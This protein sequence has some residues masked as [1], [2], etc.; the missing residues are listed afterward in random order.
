MMT[1]RSEDAKTTPR[2]AS[3]QPYELSYFARKH[4]IARAQA[5]Q[6]LDRSKSRDA[7][8]QPWRLRSPIVTAR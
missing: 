4:G 5:R 3:G 6:I 2:V 1:R 8:N 7:A